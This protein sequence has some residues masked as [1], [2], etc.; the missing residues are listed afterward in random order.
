MKSIERNE[1]LALGD[2]ESI[3][4][5]F[6]TRVI[7]EKKARRVALGPRATATFENRDTVLLQIQEM[8]RTERITREAAIVHEIETYNALIP[9]ARELSATLFIEIEDKSERDAFLISARGFER[10]VALVVD[11]Q[12]QPAL[13]DPN[14][15]LE[16]RASAVLYLRFPLSDD[17][18]K[19]VH[20]AANR[21]RDG[22]EHGLDGLV[23][24]VVSHPAYEEKATFSSATL[25]CLAEDLEN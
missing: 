3:R 12:R 8:L 21:R 6:R 10:H 9:R 20:A 1:V 25:K 15:E 14:R 16:D 18:A 4:D 24:L 7:Q 2:Y 11:G 23:E 22:A 17:A 19:A 13:W 5:R